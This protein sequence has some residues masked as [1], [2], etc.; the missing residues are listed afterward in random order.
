MEK[1]SQQ[2]LNLV[3]QQQREIRA[4]ELTEQEYFEVFCAEQILKNYDLSYDEIQRGIVDGE[5]DGGIDSIYSFINGELVYEDMDAERFRANI[6]LELHIIQSKT[7]GH[8]REST[9]NKLISVTRHLL[10][11]TSNY[12]NLTQ[13]NV[14][15]KESFDI[16]RHAYSSLAAKFPKLKI[17]YYYASKSAGDIIH[18][19]LAQKGDELR[20]IAGDMFPEADVQICFLSASRMLELTRKQPETVFTLKV[21]KNLSDSDGYVLLAPLPS[22]SD[23]IKDENDEI[24][25]E[26]FESNVRDFQGN[27]EVNKEISETLKGERTVDFWWMNNGVTILAS[28]ATLSGDS[29][30]IENPQIVNGLQTSKQ[31]ARHIVSDSDDERS[32]MVKIVSSENEDT[33]DKIIKATNSQ[34]RIQ[35]ATLRATDKVQRDIEDTLKTVGLFYDR[36]KNFYKNEGKPRD[37]IIGIPLMAQA[38]MSV[39]LASPHTARG[40]PSSLIKKDETYTQIFSSEFPLDL[41][42]NAALLTRKTDQALRNCSDFTS[43]DV[44]NIRFYVVYWLAATNIGKIKPKP[45]DVS[46]L[47]LNLV[48]DRE[49]EEAID[50]V[51]S[52]FERLGG[53]DVVAKSSDLIEELSIELEKELAH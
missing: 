36:R 43:R 45:I 49:V 9:I 51:W 5:H 3:I 35:P 33:R 22:Y 50:T 31:I 37:R 17:R 21:K 41:Y 44:T 39:V 2:L 42:K 28:K 20:E 38:V 32:V 4:P 10:S 47:K 7:T 14:S 13:Y 16:F 27:T 46:K 15:I 26:L 19:N 48:R 34:N 18:E 8:F 53:T 23:F 6:Q 25:S 30:T 1:N 11:L 12:D 40:R 52:A 29:V 24:R